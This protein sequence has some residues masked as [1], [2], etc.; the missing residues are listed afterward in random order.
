MIILLAGLLAFGQKN[1]DNRSAPP[2]ANKAHRNPALEKKI[3]AKADDIRSF[4]QP[5]AKAKLDQAICEVRRQF[6]APGN[7][8]PFAIAQKQIERKFSILPPQQSKLLRFYVLAEIARTMTAADEI[9]E[10]T[11]ERQ[12]KLQQLMEKKSQS[13][14]TLS[15]ILKTFENT[16]SDL[17]SNLK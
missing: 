6:V 1:S 3:F 7:I 4:L 10:L 9:G 12:L 8:N 5:G 2:A 16:Q 11:E 13:E 15:N 17:V 14:N